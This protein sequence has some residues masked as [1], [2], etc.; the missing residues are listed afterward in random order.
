M[1]DL[2]VILGD[3][4]QHQLIKNGAFNCI[5]AFVNKGMDAPSKMSV[6]KSLNFIEIVN[7][8]NVMSSDF[9]IETCDNED[10]VA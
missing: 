4:D 5:Q 9:D 2:L 7:H 8:F 1:N 6:I 3:N 10:Q